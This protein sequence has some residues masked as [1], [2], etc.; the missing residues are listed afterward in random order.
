MLI[1]ITDFKRLIV[2]YNSLH[3]TLI[4]NYDKKVLNKRFKQGDKF[5]IP[6]EIWWGNEIYRI[7]KIYFEK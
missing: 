3:Y 1:D 2:T 6:N 4:K 7:D 5:T